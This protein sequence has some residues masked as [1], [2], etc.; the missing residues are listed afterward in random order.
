VVPVSRLGDEELAHRVRVHAAL[1]FV[2]GVMAFNGG[3]GGNSGKA[4]ADH[5][6]FASSR[7]QLGKRADRL[8]PR[9]ARLN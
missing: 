7:S 6:A 2:A 4:R 1:P 5:P 3:P 8:R 9:H